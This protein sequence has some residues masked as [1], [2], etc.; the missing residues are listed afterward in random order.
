MSTT[1]TTTIAAYVGAAAIATANTPRTT[2][3]ATTLTSTFPPLQTDIVKYTV[4]EQEFAGTMYYDS[5]S[6]EARPLVV[7]YPDWDGV[8]EYELWRGYQVAQWGYL[9]LVADL[10]GAD[11][12]TGDD[13]PIEVCF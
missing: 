1:S 12:P 13:L 7:I 9:V 8:S 10:Y 11:I 2:A 6:D 5:S 4:G 3:N